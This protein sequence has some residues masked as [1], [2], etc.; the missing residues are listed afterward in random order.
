MQHSKGDMVMTVVE[1][2]CWVCFLGYFST[3]SGGANLLS[4]DVS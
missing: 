2:A 1:A 3:F 4:I